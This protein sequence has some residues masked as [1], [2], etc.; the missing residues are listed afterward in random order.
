MSS[1]LFRNKFS[2]PR[3]GEMRYKQ[4]NFSV[5]VGMHVKM[6]KLKK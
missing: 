1:M 5:F 2:M 4:V 6:E 3:P